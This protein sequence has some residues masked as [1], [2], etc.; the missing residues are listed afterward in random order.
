MQMPQPQRMYYWCD[1]TEANI[2]KC[3]VNLNTGGGD[4]GRYEHMYVHCAEIKC[5]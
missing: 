1:A 3:I 2:C 5:N 4:G